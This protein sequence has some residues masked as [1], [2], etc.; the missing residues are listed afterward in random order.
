M[1]GGDEEGKL[2]RLPSGRHGLSAE[3]VARN[4]R[5]RL[6]AGAIAAVV[7]SGFQDASV[8]QIAKAA[9]VSRRTFYEYFSSKEECCLDVY[10]AIE[11]E[12]LRIVSEADAGPGGWTR[13]VRRRV[14]ALVDL[15]AANPNLARFSLIAPSAAGGQ[16][17][18][19]QRQFLR[20]L[21]LRFMDGAPTSRGYATPNE[22]EFEASAGSMSAVLAAAIDTDP[23][24]ERSET[25]ARVL[26]IVLVPIVGRRLASNE[27]E[28]A[29]SDTTDQLP[30]PG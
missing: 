17:V 8:S 25:A 3:F 10:E 26:E 4:Q 18:D 19:R 9:G 14:L 29:R 30:G 7:E 12:V 23:G 13:R 20:S 2:R 1:P 15:L 28:K 27:A 24:S 21:L 16:F 6:T 11:T 22:E 5:E